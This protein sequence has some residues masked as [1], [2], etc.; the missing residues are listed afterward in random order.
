MVFEQVYNNCAR[1]ASLA[2]DARFLKE[3][4]HGFEKKSGGVGAAH[5]I[6]THDVF[7]T[8]SE[9]GRMGSAFAGRM[10]L[11]VALYSLKSAGVGE[12]VAPPNLQ[13]DCLHDDPGTRGPRDQRP[14]DQRTK[15]PAD[16]ETRNLA[17]PSKPQCWP[18]LPKKTLGPQP[19]TTQISIDVPTC[20]PCL[21]TYLATH[22]PLPGTYFCFLP[23]TFD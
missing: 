18:H 2:D 17:K 13:T 6:C 20:P 8:G 1:E 23:T 7:I 15:G 11:D 21:P 19:N 12:D 10:I 14:R 22:C 16:Q 4:L 9:R 5:P 3:S